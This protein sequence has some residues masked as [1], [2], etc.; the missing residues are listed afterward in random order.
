M[1]T[2]IRRPRQLS[3][4][5][6]VFRNGSWQME[7]RDL[8]GNKAFMPRIFWSTYLKEWNVRKTLEHVSKLNRREP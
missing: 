5:C 2:I 6:I 8:Y 1:S 7:V 4:P 3:K